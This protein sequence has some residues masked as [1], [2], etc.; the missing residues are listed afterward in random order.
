MKM[1]ITLRILAAVLIFSGAL[2]ITS[3]AKS[4][5]VQRIAAIV[6]DELITAYPAGYFFGPPS[7]HSR[8][9][10]PD[11]GAGAADPD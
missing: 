9:T 1:A 5:S 3:A 6:N 11:Q 2:T 7:Q 8:Y 10:P 4:Q